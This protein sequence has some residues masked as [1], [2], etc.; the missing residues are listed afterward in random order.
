MFSTARWY[1][2]LQEGLVGAVDEE[3]DRHRLALR[4]DAEAQ[5]ERDVARDA[6]ITRLLEITRVFAHEPAAR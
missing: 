5:K 3:D 6:Q 4:L 1:D 2:R